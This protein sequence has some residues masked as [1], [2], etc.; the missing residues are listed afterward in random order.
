VILGLI[1]VESAF[2][3]YAIS[4]V[5]ARGLMQ[6]MPFWKNYIGKKAAKPMYLIVALYD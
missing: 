6:V 3:Q 2:R 5:G 1:E 4:G